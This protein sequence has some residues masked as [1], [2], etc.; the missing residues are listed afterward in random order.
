V[1]TVIDS[2]PAWSPDGSTIAYLHADPD[3]DSSG[4]YLIDTSGINVRLIYA[5]P[6][7]GGPRWSPDGRWIAFSDGAQVFKMTSEGDSLVQLTYEGR[8][9]HPAWNGDGNLIAFSRSICEGPE[10][11]GL[12][13]VSADGGTGT[14]LV[15]Y[16]NYPD[17][18]PGENE[19]LYRTRA[20]D[21]NGI[22]FGDSIWSYSVATGQSDFITLLS[23]PNYSNSYYRYSPDGGRIAFT[24]QPDGMVPQVWLM[25][26]DGLNRN[27]LADPAYTCDWSPD[28]EW[29]V[30][31]ASG[32][33]D[34]RLWLVKSDNSSR[35]QL[36][37]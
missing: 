12:W 22:A 13:V 10:T 25:N 26:S 18:N 23:H 9:F 14:F 19:V 28:G 31:T 11:C 3:P 5:S 33:G 21:T 36:T 16:A 30:Y 32:E 17:W 8:N 4:I 35:R 15:P 1:F 24:S 7:A 29:L 20:I 6:G 37:R 27:V 2:E 34:G